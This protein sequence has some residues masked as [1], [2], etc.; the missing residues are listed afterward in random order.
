MS[1]DFELNPN[2]QQVRNTMQEELN[3]YMSA[4]VNG[5]GDKVSAY[6]P[7]DSLVN[8]KPKK[9]ISILG[10][11]RLDVRFDLRQPVNQ[12]LSIVLLGCMALSVML[13][14]F[15]HNALEVADNIAVVNSKANNSAK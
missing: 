12:W 8:R 2:I 10:L 1:K 5:D 7:S 4:I 15:T 11:F 3:P 9:S 14:Y 13:F 6:I